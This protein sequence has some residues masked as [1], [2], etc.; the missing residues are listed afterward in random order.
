MIDVTSCKINKLSGKLETWASKYRRHLTQWH[1]ECETCF[2]ICHDERGPISISPVDR[3]VRDRKGLSRARLDDPR[4]VEL[5]DDA[6]EAAI[7]VLKSIFRQC[8]L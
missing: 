8:G 1:R 3:C 6:L 4:V 2:G 7:G 5:G